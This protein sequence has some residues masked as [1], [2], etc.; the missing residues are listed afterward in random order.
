MGDFV[1][2]G[3]TNELEDGAM[4]EIIAQGVKSY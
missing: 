3:K 4:K 1:Q 2:V